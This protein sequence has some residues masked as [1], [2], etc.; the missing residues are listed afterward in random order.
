MHFWRL[1]FGLLF[2]I[3]GCTSNEETTFRVIVEV[4]SGEVLFDRVQIRLRHGAQDSLRTVGYDASSFERGLEIASFPVQIDSGDELFVITLDD[5]TVLSESTV[6]LVAGQTSA[7]VKLP[8]G[9]ATAS[10]MTTCID[11]DDCKATSECGVSTCENG[12]CREQLDDKRC[13]SG[14]TCTL[15]GCV[16][17]EPVC[18]DGIVSPEIDEA[19]DVA[20]PKKCSPSGKQCYTCF[21]CKWRKLELE[22]DVPCT[23]ESTNTSLRRETREFD[24][25][26]NNTL[27]RIEKSDG[28]P[29]SLTIS[30]WDEQNRPLTNTRDENIDGSHEYSN[31]FEYLDEERKVIWTNINGSRKVVQTE[32]F[33]EDGLIDTMVQ[34]HEG[35]ELIRRRHEYDINGNEIRRTETT[36]MGVAAET[37]VTTWLYND[38]QQAIEQRTVRQ[39]DDVTTFLRQDRYDDQKRIVLVES[40][41]NGV[42]RVQIRTKYLENNTIEETRRFDVDLDGNFDSEAVILTRNG[43]TISTHEDRDFDQVADRVT[44]YE[45]NEREERISITLVEDGNEAWRREYELNDFGQLKRERYY[46]HETLFSEV[47][48]SYDERLM[49]TKNVRSHVNEM[50]HLIPQETHEFE[51]DEHGRA[52]TQR[53]TTENLNYIHQRDYSCYYEILD[54]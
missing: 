30:T 37:K 54:R 8:S 14:G 38:D 18:G 41:E 25:N 19:C 48:V 33:R 13:V 46:D 51:R 40:F 9:C 53:V 1:S 7:T 24:S 20:E 22:D 32:I 31:T 35:Q 43:L 50:G 47:V 49:A 3:F 23:F 2:L 12:K 11:A 6:R 15:S 28:T 10:C 36:M 45:Y 52:L 27:E 21:Q 42:L 34:V 39:S 29:I 4:D 16:Y 5:T 26:G 44:T 17:N